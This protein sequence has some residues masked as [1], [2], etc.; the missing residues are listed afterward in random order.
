MHSSIA[1]NLSATFGVLTDG[2]SVLTHGDALLHLPCIFLL[3]LIF[4]IVISIQ[5]NLNHDLSFAI[6]F[7]AIAFYI[8]CHF[9]LEF[10]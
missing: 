1:I 6:V 4:L 10:L 9:V 2:F 8:I 3:L 7:P 5:I